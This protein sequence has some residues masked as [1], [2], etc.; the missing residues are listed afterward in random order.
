MRSFYLHIMCTDIGAINLHAKEPPPA[1]LPS[2]PGY[3]GGF[4]EASGRGWPQGRV[5]VPAFR[6][7]LSAF[8]LFPSSSFRHGSFTVPSLSD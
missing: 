5:R 1:P 8:P 7:P 6:F 2:D 4:A 3:A